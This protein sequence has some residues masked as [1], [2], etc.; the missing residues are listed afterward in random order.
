[1]SSSPRVPGL[2][3]PATRTAA[4]L[5]ASLAV[6][7]AL[8]PARAAGQPT[9]ADTAQA[10]PASTEG[11]FA[12][13]P[14]GHLFAPLVASP[15]EPQFRNSYLWARSRRELNT[16]LAVTEPGGTVSLLRRRGRQPGD[17][18]ELSI[19]ASVAAQFD[20]S[21]DHWDLLNAD[22]TFS[23]P[24]TYRRGATA[25]RLRFSHLSS[26]LGDEYLLYRERRPEFTGTY[27]REAVELLVSHDV[28]RWRVYGGGEHAYST[29]PGALERNALEGGVE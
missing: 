26:H 14:G 2:A 27:R 5:G 11:R 24:I 13:F 15:K 4:T 17:G 20:L 16:R 3:R 19:Q 28:G 9:P 7:G 12:V 10:R 23:Y 8:A 29:A 22:Y 1:M 21:S 25:A 6:L 18:I